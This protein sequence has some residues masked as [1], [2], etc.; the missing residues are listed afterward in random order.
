MVGVLLQ[1]KTFGIVAIFTKAFVKKEK[2]ALGLNQKT[3]NRQST[4]SST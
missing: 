2:K 3:W 4:D 1:N